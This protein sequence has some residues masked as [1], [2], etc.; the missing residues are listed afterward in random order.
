MTVT[1]WRCLFCGYFWHSVPLDYDNEIPSS[2][3]E[4]GCVKGKWVFDADGKIERDYCRV[5]RIAE[6]CEEFVNHAKASDNNSTTEV[7]RD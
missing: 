4:M 1:D 5:M 3:F 2:N 7:S 6:T